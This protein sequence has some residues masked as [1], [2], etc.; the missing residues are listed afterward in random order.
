LPNL[1]NFKPDS[2]PPGSSIDIIIATLNR[3][4][5]VKNLVHSIEKQLTE[6]DRIIVIWQGSKKPALAESEFVRCIYGS[7]PN[8]PKARNKGI[9]EGKG[10]ICL[11]FD[12]D[13]EIISPDILKTHRT[14]H[15]Q[16]DIGAVA[17]YIEDPIFDLSKT[18]VSE[19]NETTGE[20]VQN[21]S[22]NKSQF[23]SSIMGAHM[24]FK[25]RALSA[26]NG[27]DESFKGNALW[28][29]VDCAFRLRKAGWKVFY[30]AE[31]K[32]RHVREKRGGCR[33]AKEKS[34]GYIYRQ[35]ANT[36]Y[37]ACKHAPRQF[38]RSWFGFWKY[39][40]E[41]LSRN[42]WLWVKHDPGLVLAGLFGA[43]RGIVQYWMKKK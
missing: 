24:S 27:F 20:L 4:T 34:A 35:F 39:R 11:F 37:F 41:F 6:S 43:C 2:P 18:E 25:R 8:L 13:V 10:D 31:A 19:F 38:L 14:V 1:K 26:I 21:F 30:C 28:E 16:N 7:A 5:G 29:E 3:P 33:T 15:R 40:L 23:S 17:G 42:H 32:V 9:S 12:D 22:I 36:A